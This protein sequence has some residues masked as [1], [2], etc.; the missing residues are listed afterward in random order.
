MM[1]F[2]LQEFKQ[3]IFEQKMDCWSKYYKEKEKENASNIDLIHYSAKAE[4]FNFVLNLLE[5]SF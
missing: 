4:A 2:D 3:L 5:K 1:M